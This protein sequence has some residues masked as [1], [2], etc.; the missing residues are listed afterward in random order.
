[1]NRIFLVTALGIA[2]I[3]MGLVR[4]DAAGGGTKVGYVDLQ[5]TLNETK[6]GKSAKKKLER[7]KARKQKELDKKQQQLKKFAA[8]FE[9]QRGVLKPAAVAKRQRELEKKY[10]ELQEMYMKLQ[11]DLAK[12][13][14]KLVR[15]IFKKAQPA[16]QAI[17][18]EKGFS[19]I[20]EKNEGAVL[21]AGKAYDITSEVNKRVK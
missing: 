7:D 13:E 15:A 5:R 14:A 17:A 20:L 12:E 11:Q 2:F 19:M 6:A 8:D 4:A 10:V 3:T 9:R 16:I 1:M 21:W 18:R